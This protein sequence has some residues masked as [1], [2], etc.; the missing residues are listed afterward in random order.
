MQIEL[1]DVRGRLIRDVLNDGAL[2]AGTHTI[3][4]PGQA[5]NGSPLAEGIY[6]YR[7][8]AGGEIRNGRVVIV[9]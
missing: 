9:R 1:Y 5:A 8:R 2:A 7:I 4:V 6:Y 3:W